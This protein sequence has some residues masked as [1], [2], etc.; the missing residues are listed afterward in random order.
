M[1]FVSWL[2]LWLLTLAAALVLVYI[3]IAGALVFFL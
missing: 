3:M 2:L 1:R